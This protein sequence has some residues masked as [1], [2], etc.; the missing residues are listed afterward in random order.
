MPGSSMSAWV[1]VRIWVRVWGVGLWVRRRWE[2]GRAAAKG[3]RIIWGGFGEGIG[4]NISMIAELFA[5]R[6]VCRVCEYPDSW[7]RSST[8]LGRAYKYAGSEV[9][10]TESSNSFLAVAAKKFTLRLRPLLTAPIH[11]PIFHRPF[12]PR[13]QPYRSATTLKLAQ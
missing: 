3:R 11:H 2:I 9:G 1:R 10:R 4:E 6:R 12:H 13:H 8:R 5:P 7:S